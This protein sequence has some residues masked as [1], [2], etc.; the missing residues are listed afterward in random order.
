MQPLAACLAAGGPAAAQSI[1]IDHRNA[2]HQGVPVS[3]VQRARET[4][5]IAYGHTS[6]GSQLVS[7]MSGLVGFMNAKDD[8]AFPDNA[9]AFNSGGSNVLPATDI[10]LAGVADIDQLL[11]RIEG[12]SLDNSGSFWHANGQLLPW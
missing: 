9:F 8:D 3:A 12:L 6:H 7:G 4:L 10:A 2:T 5:H 11:A 1:I